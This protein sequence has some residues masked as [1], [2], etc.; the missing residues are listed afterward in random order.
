ML[1]SNALIFVN[2]LPIIEHLVL[3]TSSPWS[4]FG[5]IFME[6]MCACPYLR[7]YTLYIRNK[8]IRSNLPMTYMTLRSLESVLV[9]AV[10]GQ[11]DS[12]CVCKTRLLCSLDVRSVTEWSHL[13][14]LPSQCI[15]CIS[16]YVVCSYCLLLC[17]LCMLQ[18]WYIV[19]L[20]SYHSHCSWSL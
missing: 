8:M 15:P 6:C 3:I 10:R 5:H 19:V 1:S 14:I 11:V 12:W 13:V 2:M 4:Y 20:L 16:L 7:P 18:T 9:T 17:D